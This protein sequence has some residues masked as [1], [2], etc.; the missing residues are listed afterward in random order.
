MPLPYL[1]GNNGIKRYSLSCREDDMCLFIHFQDAPFALPV[2][3]ALLHPVGDEVR[4]GYRLIPML[5]GECHG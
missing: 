2:F 5:W 4:N 1:K 3:P